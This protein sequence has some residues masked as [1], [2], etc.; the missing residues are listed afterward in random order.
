[1]K[2]QH[3]HFEELVKKHTAEQK[4]S[5][6]Q[7]KVE[8]TERKQT[9]EVLQE[10]L[11]LIGK[12]KREWESTV[13]SIPQLVCLIDAQG[14]ILRA[15]RVV[16]QWNLGQVLNVKCKSLHELL[17]PGC[18]D[19]TCYLEAF[20]SQAWVKLKHGRYTECEIND[21]ALGRYI[22]IQVRPILPK[23]YRKGEETDS[24][25]VVVINDI[26]EHR[27]ADEEL[28][29][30]K[31]KSE[32]ILNSAR[33]GIIGLD[34][35]G[36]H[37]FVNLSA[38]KML[39]YE[40]EE[41]IGQK[42]HA[43]W[44]HTKADGAPHLEEKCPIYAAYRDGEV[45]HVKDE[46]FWR[47]DSTSFPVAYTST[48][49][50]EDDNLIGAVVTFRDITE[51]KRT[52]EMLTKTLN[53]QKN[54]MDTIPD[55]IYLLD[56][57]ANLVK[58]NKRAEIV[59]GFSSE[60]LAGKYVLDFFP[61]QDKIT[62]IRAIQKAFEKGFSKTEG[63]LLRK[64]GTEVLHEWTGVPFKD[65][66]DAI[67]GLVGIGRDITDRRK[68][69]KDLWGS[70]ERYRALVDNTVLG[71]AVMDTNYRIIMVNPTFAKLFKR[72]ASDL[73]GKYCFREFEKREAVCPHCPGKRAMVSGK[74]EEVETQGERD[75]G[76]HFY[77]HHRAAPLFGSDGAL[78][79]FLEMVED[80]DIR[81]KTEE[82][83][84]ETRDY[85]EKLLNYANA[86]I[87]VWDT[88]SIITRFNHAFE[89]LT[90]YTNK[91]VIGKKLHIL[92]PEVSR[93]ESLKK[94]ERTLSGEYWE[95]VEIPVLCKD[96]SIK[97]ALWNS[98]NIYTKD[99]GTLVA[100]IAQGQDITDRKQ[101]EEALRQSENNYR[102]LLENLPQK[103]FLKDKNSVYISCNENYAHDLGVNPHEIAGK[104]D[105]DF[106]PKEL[107][108]KYRTDDKR[109]M[110]SGK[111]EDI[112][113]KYIQDGTEVFIQTV[114]TPVK[115]EEGNIIAVQGIFWDITE[116]KQAEK[117][118][119]KSREHLEEIVKARTAQLE[120]ANRELEAFSYSV[121]H[122]L[123]APLRAIAGFSSILIEDHYD[124]L[125][126]EGKH[127]LNV[128]Q[129]NAQKMGE[130][131]DDL[132]ALSRVGRKEIDL[133]E[134]D[135]DKLAK[136]VFDEIKATV[137]ER[138]IQFD[139]KP[140]PSTNCDEGLLRQVFFN[141]LF[142]AIKFTKFKEKAIIEVGGYAE[143]AENVYY[144]KD[145]GVGF[146][147]QYNDK[148]FRAF[149]RL[150]S[151]KEFEGTGIGL[152][153]VQ[154]VINRHGG[155]TWAEGKV[156]E[157]ATFYFTLPNLS[158]ISPSV[159]V[160]S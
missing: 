23:V 19:S 5:K 160:R 95:S 125:D 132:L 42:S 3:G 44:H 102:T 101:A 4:K 49:I 13:D 16:E 86:P 79:G 9:E 128:V 60:E 89:R 40:V 56:M 61:K 54:I 130:L 103:I 131:I 15:N 63:H 50:L 109:I 38:A 82:S 93:K 152:A 1:L 72:S 155:K 37:T 48:P 124:K 28:E 137:P 98:A 113:E 73:V 136:T 140:L 43:I 129:G 24:Y 147:M 145:N 12:A 22:N 27:Q 8:A 6:E 20:W 123:K 70:Q 32:L 141:L 87:I 119:T 62:M 36:K 99:A 81:K 31:R 107:A 157:E 11:M 92:F 7:L 47:K 105:Y 52:A 39:G 115:D 106:F 138:E 57:N 143:G 64:N 74:T 69:E 110:E 29:Q 153:T 150:H 88:K 139:I 58:W 34:Q 104:K 127:L 77:V 151:D 83:L 122:D 78:K 53:E 2:K 135:M 67:I 117:E 158:Y 159:K 35:E 46:V 134:I 111:T 66:Q 121:S 100:T 126:D 146:D 65:E 30:L 41:L 94:I 112:E 144:V 149:Q 10:R 90:G 51:S 85:L 68:A 25:A 21:K 76:N 108:D 97:I 118:L 18:A 156:N 116:R 133:S 71:I 154:R 80:I 55:I 148:L 14:R 96:G 26:T 120:A 59:T 45:R 17:H 75:D 33:E 142:N 84:R 91:E 114:K